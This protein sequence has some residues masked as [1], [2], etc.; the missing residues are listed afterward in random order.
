MNTTMM[1]SQ[2]LHFK[3]WIVVLIGTAKSITHTCRDGL[4]R[5]GRR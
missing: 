4:K 3:E 1:Q 2:F 5:Q